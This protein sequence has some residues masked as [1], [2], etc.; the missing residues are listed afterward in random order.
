MQ[1]ND[2]FIVTRLKDGVFNIVEQ[3]IYFIAA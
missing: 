3:N 1:K 2:H